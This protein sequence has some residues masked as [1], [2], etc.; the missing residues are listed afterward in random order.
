[1]LFFLGAEP[2]RDTVVQI[3]CSLWLRGHLG[4]SDI[5]GNG[6]VEQNECWRRNWEEFPF[7]ELLT[8]LT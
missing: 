2:D 7:E 1:M 8:D 5:F 4:S 6:V 3:I